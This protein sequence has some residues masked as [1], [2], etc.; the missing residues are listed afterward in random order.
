MKTKR[1]LP[2][3]AP[4]IIQNR[5]YDGQQA[6]VWSAGVMLYVMLYCQYPF[7]KPEDDDDPPRKMEKVMAKASNAHSSSS[8]QSIQSLFDAV[9]PVPLCE[10]GRMMPT[11][12]G[13]CRRRWAVSYLTWVLKDL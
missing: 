9:L 6:D 10:S 3:A 11:L 8:S 2:S 12:P 7:E 4:E 1:V 5:H 13:R